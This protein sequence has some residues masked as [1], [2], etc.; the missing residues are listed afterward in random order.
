[1]LCSGTRLYR[2]HT[3]T[4]SPNRLEARWKHT[5]LTV[6]LIS[7]PS[8]EWQGEGIV[9]VRNTNKSIVGGG[10]GLC[11]DIHNLRTHTA[12][13]VAYCH[14]LASYLVAAGNWV[15]LLPSNYQLEF[16]FVEE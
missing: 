6:P 3:L 8:W 2:T 12:A 14:C 1:M 5:D 7:G 10:S 16:T 15:I 13:A 4:V 11:L 9:D